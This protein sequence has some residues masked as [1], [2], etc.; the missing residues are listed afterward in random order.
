MEGEKDVPN[1]KDTDPGPPRPCAS[2]AAPRGGGGPMRSVRRRYGLWG[3]WRANM[4]MPVRDG[5]VGTGDITGGGCGAYACA[6]PKGGGS[7]Q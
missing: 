6:L 2:D 7:D 3:G 1:V 4:R 5:S